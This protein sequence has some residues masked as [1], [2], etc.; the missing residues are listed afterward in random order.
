M[1]QVIIILAVIFIMGGSIFLASYFMAQKQEPPQ[2]PVEDLVRA[3]KA[4]KV[5]YSDISAIIET[6]GRLGSNQYVDLITEVTGEILPGDVSLKKGEG[7]REG[8]LLFRVFDEETRYGLKA[9]KS[10]FLNSIANVLPDIKIDFPD[11]YDEW[12]TFFN[13]IEI[14][15]PLPELPEFRS[16]KE[17][18][19]IASK[20][21][22]TDYYTIL[23]SEVRLSKYNIY[24]PFRGSFSEVYLEVGSVANPGTR[25]ARIIRTDKL[26]LEVPV[27]VEDIKWISNGNKVDVFSEDGSAKWTGQIVRK[28]GFVDPQ[29]QSVGVFISVVP[30]EDM[31]LYEGQYLRAVFTGKEISNAMRIPR[32]AVFNSD[33]VFI[34]R[35][36]ELYKEKI[37]IHKLA[38]ETVIFSGIPEGIYVVTEPLINIPERT[39]VEITNN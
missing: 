3:V 19:F 32:N 38:D 13:R 17:K 7:F 35:D 27:D 1:R 31:P 22:L 39:R 9:S 5:Q 29:T 30:N 20:N 2:K 34:V 16:D 14:G 12:N 18:T 4:E 28:S 8:Q 21:I 26:E 23:S 25:V 15:K 6:T 33:E 37:N 11:N 24:A 36:D 10:R